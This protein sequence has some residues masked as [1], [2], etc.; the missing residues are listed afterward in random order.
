MFLRATHFFFFFWGPN[1]VDSVPLRV[2]TDIRG[3]PAWL[4]LDGG[5]VKPADKTSAS[6]RCPVLLSVIQTPS[7][8]LFAAFVANT[9]ARANFPAIA[10]CER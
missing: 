1:I 2:I 5:R 3:V 10:D 9:Q 4:L 8:A 6:Q 7:A